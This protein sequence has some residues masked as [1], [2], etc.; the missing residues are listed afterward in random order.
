MA[1][2]QETFEQA[3]QEIYDEAF[4]L[5]C[6]KQ[7]RYGN[8]NIE[9]LGLHGVISRIA[10][11]KIARA[12]KFLN[13]RIVGGQV[14]LNEMDDDQ[15]ESLEDTLLDIANYALIAVALRRGKWGRPLKVDIVKR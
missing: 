15:E 8:S 11:D 14:F 12:K 2:N 3:F 6:D 13:G 7:A 5:L 10:H 1:S 4:K 9:Q